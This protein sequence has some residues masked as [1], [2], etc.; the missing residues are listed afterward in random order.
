[1]NEW[2][3]ILGMKKLGYFGALLPSE[4]SYLFW[5]LGQNGLKWLAQPQPGHSALDLE[6]VGAGPVNIER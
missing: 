1:M 4:F 3:F 5:N 6:A 2:V